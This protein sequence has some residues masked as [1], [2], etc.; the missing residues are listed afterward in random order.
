MADFDQQDNH[1]GEIDDSKVGYVKLLFK[2]PPILK[3]FYR[4]RTTPL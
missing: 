1:N 2:T 4:L 3:Y